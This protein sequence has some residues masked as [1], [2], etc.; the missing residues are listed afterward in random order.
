VRLKRVLD[1]A[2][3]LLASFLIAT[4]LIVLVEMAGLNLVS[5]AE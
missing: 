2:L 1:V 5:L 4:A 3:V